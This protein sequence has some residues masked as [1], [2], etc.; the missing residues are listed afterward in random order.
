M[1]DISKLRN[2]GP[3]SAENFAELGIHSRDDLAEWGPVKVWHA[4]K[5]AGKPVTR[6]MVYAIQGALLDTHWN[7]LP[8][9]L[10]DELNRQ[11]DVMESKL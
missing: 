5:T 8:P 1:S 11:C 10:K 4:L 3:K 2:L 7:D 6:V 9:G